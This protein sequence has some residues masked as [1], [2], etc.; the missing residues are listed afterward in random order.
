MIYKKTVFTL[1]M[2]VC[3]LG[4]FSQGGW[5]MK[6]IPISSIDT[7]YLGKEIRID[8]KAN[9]LDTIN[10]EVKILEIRRLLSNRDSVQLSVNG[11]EI[12]FIE[13]WR[14]YV[15]QGILRE[16]SL[17]SIN[18]NRIQIKEIVLKSI[19]DLTLT[20]EISIYDNKCNP[21]VMKE[22]IIIKKSKIKGFLV[23]FK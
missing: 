4:A 23:N 5:N 19:N 11:K 3:S 17:E 21:S 6:Y 1:I 20:F 12:N 7:T 9:E 16:Q 18:N 8:F 10:G 14:L 22:N 13:I 15:D 2:I